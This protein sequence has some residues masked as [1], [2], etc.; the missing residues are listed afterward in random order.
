MTGA[1]KEPLVDLMWG[2]GRGD[3][4]R[5]LIACARELYSVPGSR[6]SA[7]DSEVGNQVLERPGGVGVCYFAEEREQ[8]ERTK[9]RSRWRAG[10]VGETIGTGEGTLE[11][12]GETG[13]P[14]GMTSLLVLTHLLDSFGAW[15]Q[16]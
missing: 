12:I 8:V 4:S 2:K 3:N 16:E 10:R 14:R 15:R 7:S 6:L 11:G 13:Q 9:E 5:S 1:E